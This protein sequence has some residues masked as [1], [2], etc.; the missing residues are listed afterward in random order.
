MAYLFLARNELSRT[1]TSEIIEA[2]VGLNVRN[3]VN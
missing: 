3:C 2:H 1:V